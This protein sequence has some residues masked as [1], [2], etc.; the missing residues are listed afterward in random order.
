MTI[1]QI[2]AIITAGL[3]TG[4]VTYGAMAAIEDIIELKKLKQRIKT[5][6]F[7]VSDM[8]ERATEDLE[9]YSED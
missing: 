6:E 5:L 4:I 8:L 7:I 9:D 3:V 1:W 2:I